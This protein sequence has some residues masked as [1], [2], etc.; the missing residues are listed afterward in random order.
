[1]KKT[2]L[3]FLAGLIILSS[4]LATKPSV[5]DKT[6]TVHSV[7]VY[8]SAM[9]DQSAAEIVAFDK[10]NNQVLCT[11]GSDGSLTIL[12]ASGN[13]LSKAAGVAFPG[14][15]A[16]SVSVSG[17]LAAVAVAA[18]DKVSPGKVYFVNLAD[19]TVK[20]EV[21]VGALPDMVKFTPDGKYVL[22]A[23]E[24]EPS[25]GY[26]ADPDGSV[27]LITV[28]KKDL[29]ASPVTT[30]TFS[31]SD[32]AADASGVPVR[33]HDYLSSMPTGFSVAQDME[34]EYIAVDEDSRYAYV[35]CQENNAVAKIDIPNGSVITVKSLGYKD[36]SLSGLDC[37]E[38]GTAHI[39]AQPVYGIYMP[40]SITCFEIDGKTYLATANEGDDRA[41]WED[42]TAVED[43]DCTK[44][45]NLG[46]FGL[47]LDDV[48]LD[49][50]GK[51][52]AEYKSLKVSPYDCIDSDHDGDIDILA[53]FGARSF[54]IWDEDLNLVY[55]S[56]SLFEE[57][58]AD[59][60]PE[61]F[62]CSNDN[63]VIEDRSPKKG[64]EPEAIAYG[65]VDGVPLVFVGLERFGGFFVF[66]VTD[67]EQPEMLLYHTDRNFSASFDEEGEYS[68][69][70]LANTGDLGPEGF[71]FVPAKSSLSGKAQLIT[72]SEISGT[73]RVYDISFN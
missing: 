6:L 5:T 60:A 67:P 62:N 21:E 4:C 12:S 57:Y 46:D 15:D 70:S 27:S 69:D 26:A 43:Y 28:N 37:Y 50:E 7:M 72:G 13:S 11:N 9:Y 44:A 73:V 39:I 33:T 10:K 47:M 35:C 56:G 18:S 49:S 25:E 40:D 68:D 71:S 3:L 2:Y 61:F 53:S 34:P 58:T 20:G 55:D 64:P 66:D 1:M 51:I 23:N 59:L 24:G 41:D 63:M 14:G 30:L 38:D 45:K 52:L 36:Y 42:G 19:G 29:S 8:D 65:E 32:L 31:A 22:V 17:D 54:S 48:F 16:N